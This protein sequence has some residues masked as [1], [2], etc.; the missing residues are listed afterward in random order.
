[1][2]M[3]TGKATVR[4]VAREAGVSPGTVSMILNARAGV[5]FAKQTEARVRAAAERL[6][7]APPRAAGRA[8]DRPV[9]AVVLT[10]VTGSYYTF[11]SQAITQQA[12]AAGYDTV[13]FET[14]RSA[15]R[16]LRLLHMI[17]R[18]GCAGVVFTVPPINMKEAA[19]LSK[20]VPTVVISS[21][22][23]ETGLDTVMTDDYFAGTM[24]AEHLLSLGHRRVAFIDIDR[25]W[26]NVLANTRL[27]GVKEK[28][29]QYPDAQLFIHGRR[30]PDTLRPGSFIES[31][32]LA[33]EAAAE[34]LS[35]H[36]VTAF[37]GV[38]DYAAY[39][40]LDELAARHMRVPEDYSVC[41]FDD[42]F[43][44]GLPGVELTTTNRH[45]VETGLSA[46]ELLLTKM[47]DAS[48]APRITRVE[49]MSRLIVRRSTGAPG[50]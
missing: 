45:P 49:Y 19:R 7:Y 24:V 15:E 2:S 17:S 35:E 37:I 23:K 8:F 50:R 47:Q 1:M 32:S 26:Q 11:I 43:A 18:I 30:G 21:G 22:R 3:S 46:F 13:C 9:I 40:I 33:R 14:H 42:I 4:D 48:A 34:C 39:G 38:S 28:F 6:G 29:S 20:A 27:D 41:G 36:D 31:R 44:S 10:I 12:N 25:T 5:S 16:E